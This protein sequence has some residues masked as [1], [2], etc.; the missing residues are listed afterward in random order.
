MLR[1]LDKELTGGT[2]TGGPGS[3]PGSSIPV[4]T[5]GWGWYSFRIGTRHVRAR[6]QLIPGTPTLEM[7]DHGVELEENRRA[8]ETVVEGSDAT[9]G[10]D[11]GVAIGEGVHTGTSTAAGA[12]PTYSETGSS[13]RTVAANNTTTT[14][15]VHR[16]ASTEPYAVTSTPYRMRITLEVDETAGST[17]GEAEGPGSAAPERGRFR[18]RRTIVEEGDVGTLRENVPLSL[19]VPDGDTGP[20]PSASGGTDGAADDWLAPPALDGL[21]PPRLGHDPSLLG[22]DVRRA[23]GTTGPFTWPGIGLDVR[24]FVGKANLRAANNYAIKRSYDAGFSLDG[25]DPL[26]RAK[27][28]GLTRLGTGSAQVLED[29]TGDAALAAYFHRAVTV[30]AYQVAGLTEKSLAGTETARLDLYAKPDFGG[31]RLLTVAD[32]MKMEVIRRVSKG[33]GTSAGQE[34][35]QDTALGGGVLVSSEHTGLNQLGVSGTG[36]Y[37]SGGD[38][39]TVATDHLASINVKPKTGRSFLFAVPTRWLSVADVH[40]GTKDTALGRWVRGTFGAAASTLSTASSDTYA[41]AWIRDDIARELGLIT[42]RNFPPGVDAAWDAVTTA[43]KAWIAADTAYWDRRRTAVDL[44]AERDTA[45][46]R[47]DAARAR[48]QATQPP[49]DRAAAAVTAAANAVTD[50]R[51]DAATERAADDL[52]VTAAREALDAVDDSRPDHDGW[53]EILDAQRDAAGAALATAERETAGRRRAAD[54]RIQEAGAGKADADRRLA[55]L[56]TALADA[57]ADVA[58]STARRD[59]ARTA[60][61]ALRAELDGLRDTAER[62]AAEY[63]R[64]RAATDRLTRWHQRAA[65]HGAPPPPGAPP[66]PPAVTYQAPPK[67]PDPAVPPRPRYTRTDTAAGRELTSPAQER[68]LLGEVPRDGD[69]FLHAL[70]AALHAADPGLLADA[71]IDP[72]DPA[73]ALARTRLLLAARLADPADADLLDWLA[74]DDTD[75]FTEAEV[76][77]LAADAATD[78]G[79]GAP[80]GT[81]APRREFEALGG[82]LPHSLDL[83]PAARAALTATQVTRPPAAG[84][85]V[86]DDAAADLLPMLAARTFG[87]RVTVVLEDG[88]ALVHPAVRRD[89]D[90]GLLTVLQD[91]AEHRVRDVVLSLEDRHYRPAVP[92]GSEERTPAPKDAED[93]VPPKGAEVPVPPEDTA[94]PPPSTDTSEAPPPPP[95]P[96]LVSP[97]PKGGSGTRVA[98]PARGV[99][100]RVPATG[101][102]LLYSFLASDPRTVRDA[103]PGAA[104]LDPETYDWLGDPVR[105][106]LELRAHAQAHSATGVLPPGR[107]RA[108]VDAMRSFV[109]AYVRDSGGRLPAEVLG[110]LRRTTTAPFAARVAGLRRDALVELLVHHGADPDTL[111]PLDEGR[112]RDELLA[113]RTASTAPL[114][115]VEFRELLHAVEHWRDFWSD[116]TGEAFLPLLAHALAVRVD[117][118]RDG[119]LV[120]QVGPDD[121]ARRIEVAY[122]GSDHYNGAVLYGGSVLPK[123][124]KPEERDTEGDVRLNPLWTP[125]DEVDPDLLVTAGEDAVWLYTVTED[126][127]VLVGSERPSAIITPEQF[128][129]LLAGMRSRHRRRRRRRRAMTADKL[130]ACLDGLGHTGIAAGFAAEGRTRPG[131]SRVSGEFR[132]NAERQRWTVNDKSGRY[133]SDQV[134][135]GLDAAEAAVWLENVALLFSDRLGVVVVPDQVKTAAPERHPPPVAASSSAVSAGAVGDRFA[136]ALLEAMGTVDA[137][138]DRRPDWFLP[139]DDLPTAQ[140][141][142]VGVPLT[143]GQ[144]AESVLLGGTLNTAGLNLTRPQQLRLLLRR[145]S[146]PARENVDT[147]AE[148]LAQA[149]GIVI[150][151]TGADGV[152]R[153]YGSGSGPVVRFSFDA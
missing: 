79:L 77:A 72:G 137:L 70:I 26:G 136:D 54:L 35:T 113:V 58:A 151:W 22:P 67:A 93:P 76:A 141:T 73:A 56:D 43:S 3:G 138:G 98:P 47:S 101:E 102:C 33:A 132:W 123:R 147:T 107:S 91:G 30:Q 52:L 134:R 88:T 110:Q 6:V 87:V 135:P 65:A 84:R 103:L 49:R 29:G 142:A 104:A 31:A 46:A 32:G 9:S 2:E 18:G 120:T 96:P 128:D 78:L 89:G 114:D 66:E 19:M 7:L 64:V 82:V 143:A 63:H 115:D 38:S 61:A 57:N 59:T 20:D 45:Q 83:G 127:R 126:G 124:V 108:V 97:S 125:L 69:A 119:T 106:R 111:G 39:V 17:P 27:D 116:A 11:L 105:V 15:T 153:R 144:L 40:R 74:P 12:G 130:R 146:P 94:V 55:T 131:R 112:L 133:M 121:A 99:P 129:A 4:R 8:I 139:E 41:L 60:L 149:L 16:V 13:R 51:R 150:E 152:V 140:L 53:A 10:S 25:P 80:G 62:A 148:A 37:D 28:T 145:G 86:W 23:D 68:Y 109:A 24:G 85:T 21:A 95:V 90:T 75:T 71:G 117:V 122:N 81:S 14:M 118:A 36:P 50:A 34:N 92:V 44:I 42:D 100:V 5:G 48:V 1:A